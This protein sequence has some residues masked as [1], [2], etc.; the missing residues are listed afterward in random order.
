MRST[1]SSSTWRPGTIRQLTYGAWVDETPRWLADGRILF[2]SGR[3]GVLNVFSVDTLGN[4]RRETSAWTGAFDAAP[5]GDRDAF[6]V[7]GFHDLSLGIYLYPGDSTARQES[8]ALTEPPEHSRWEWPAGETGDVARM[9]GQ[10]YRRKY[11]LDF[12]AGEFAYVPRVGTGQGATFLVSDLLSDNLFYF[13]LST[14]QGRRFGSLFENISVLGLYLNQTRRL[15]WGVGLFRFKGNQY[16]GDFFRG[17]HREH[18]GRL[19]AAALPAVQVCAGRGAVLGG[20]LRSGRFHL[21][22]CRSPA[23]GMDRVAI[24]LLHPR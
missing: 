6:L 15:N 11:T 19:R 4:G 14:F 22:G 2:S 21:A 13:N 24:H 1:C 18:R 12:A 20:A 10:P 17:L 23:G 16:E 7:G 9:K 8:F 5:A 3:D